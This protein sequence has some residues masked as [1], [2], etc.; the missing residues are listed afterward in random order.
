MRGIAPVLL[1]ATLAAA[2]AAQ[3]REIKEYATEE[4]ARK[5]CPKD[6]IVWSEVKGGGYYHLRDSRWYGKTRDG[7][8]L[9][10]KEATAA[11]WKEY[12]RTRPE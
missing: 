3:A 9:C 6:E 8:Y 1:I 4:A 7:A 11:G 5:H 10:R 12:P 2:S